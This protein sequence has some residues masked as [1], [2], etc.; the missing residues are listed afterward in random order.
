MISST[1]AKAILRKH[2]VGDIKIMKQ[3]DVY[4]PTSRIPTIINHLSP[5][6][7]KSGNVTVKNNTFCHSFLFSGN[8]F[9]L[10]IQRRVDW[11]RHEMQRRVCEAQA[12]SDG[13]RSN[14]WFAARESARAENHLQSLAGRSRATRRSRRAQRAGNSPFSLSRASRR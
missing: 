4:G 6:I 13:D 5:S 10:F 9:T 1:P 8:N 12:S 7:K 2:S 14:D 11:R 3:Y